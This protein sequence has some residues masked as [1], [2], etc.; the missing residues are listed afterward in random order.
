[1]VYF[2]NSPSSVCIYILVVVQGKKKNQNFLLKRLKKKLHHAV[3]TA[4]HVDSF[5]RPSSALV[6]LFVS[7]A[8]FSQT[9]LENQKVQCQYFARGLCSLHGPLYSSMMKKPTLF[10]AKVIAVYCSYFLLC[11]RNSSTSFR[12]LVQDI[13]SLVQFYHESK[14]F[15]F[16]RTMKVNW[17]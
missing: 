11:N 5:Q 3:F 2:F 9:S 1:M 4:E 15:S 14:Q 13:S 12:Y 10:Q 7:Q 17:M 8:I 6:S 16:L